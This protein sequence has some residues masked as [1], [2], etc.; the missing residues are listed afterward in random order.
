MEATAAALNFQVSAIFR[1]TGTS[2]PRSAACRI[3]RRSRQRLAGVHAP[4]APNAR[5]FALAPPPSALA[6]LVDA[7]HCAVPWPGYLGIRCR[8]P[9]PPRSGTQPHQFTPAPCPG[10]DRPGT[11]QQSA[12]AAAPHAAA[13]GQ[14]EPHGVGCFVLTEIGKHFSA[15]RRS[16]PATVNWRMSGPVGMQFGGNFGWGKSWSNALS[17]PRPISRSSSTLSRKK[18]GR[19]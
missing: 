7:Y 5:E 4:P 17:S 2:A 12:S 3:A 13:C 15:P 8:D 18:A 1:N 6:P 10:L 16:L 14:S 19:R 9:L 11:R